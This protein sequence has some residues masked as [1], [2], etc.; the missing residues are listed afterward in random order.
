MRN[1][2]RSCL[3]GWLRVKALTNEA[4]CLCAGLLLDLFFYDL[5]ILILHTLQ[6]CI[7]LALY[8]IAA[9]CFWTLNHDFTPMLSAVQINLK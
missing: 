2:A 4:R 5:V 6:R 3:G 1:T 8:G 7:W 9:P